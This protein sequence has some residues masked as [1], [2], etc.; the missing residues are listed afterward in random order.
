MQ[1]RLERA[2]ARRG[3]PRASAPLPTLSP[4]PPLSK[5]GSYPLRAASS[6]LLATWVLSWVSCALG[7]P[8]PPHPVQPTLTSTP[9]KA[10]TL[11]SPLHQGLRPAGPLH[12]HSHEGP[13]LTPTP[14]PWYRTP[15]PVHSL[16]RPSEHLGKASWAGSG[17][18]RRQE[19][20]CC[21][22]LPSGPG[23]ASWALMGSSWSR[24]V[25]PGS[26][27]RRSSQAAPMLRVWWWWETSPGAR[28]PLSA[29]SEGQR[30]GRG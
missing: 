3:L 27:L 28:L 12:L 18:R 25:I 8:P 10:L 1:I 16:P 9:Q 11:C 24:A 17:Q 2:R 23:S 21:A 7:A 6:A 4:P 30:G 26:T 15:L 5:C 20:P 19:P 14:P 13:R 22:L 29:S